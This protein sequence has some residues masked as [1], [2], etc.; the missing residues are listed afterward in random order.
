ML[1]AQHL[2]RKDLEEQMHLP[3]VCHK[4]EVKKVIVIKG[5]ECHFLSVALITMSADSHSTC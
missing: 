2:V 4:T 1:N 3:E 5:K